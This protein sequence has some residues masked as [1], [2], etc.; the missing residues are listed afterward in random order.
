MSQFYFLTWSCKQRAKLV[1]F[2]TTY[3]GWDC[4]SEF[5]FFLLSP[6][7]SFCLC[8]LH[9]SAG[10]LPSWPRPTRCLGLSWRT[11][12]SGTCATSGS[13][14]R[15]VCPTDNQFFFVFFFLVVINVALEM[16]SLSWSESLKWDC[17]SPI[18]SQGRASFLRAWN[19][20]TGE[21]GCVLSLY[22]SRKST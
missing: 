1:F 22:H 10:W 3:P 14:A 16:D 6:S 12:P 5:F 17:V 20:A 19:Q 7:F 11:R 9:H 13:K 2:L 15:C 4:D 21:Y 18:L 8:P